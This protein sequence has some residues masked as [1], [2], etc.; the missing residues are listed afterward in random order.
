MIEKIFK[1]RE[2]YF[3][4]PALNTSR[5]KAFDADPANMLKDDTTTSNALS[6][7]SAAD[8]LLYDGIEAY[9]QQFYISRVAVPTE[10]A[11]TLANYLIDFAKRTQEPI[12]EEIFLQ[13][14]ETLNLWSNIKDPVKRLAK[15]TPD[16]NA[17]I[18]ESVAQKDKICLSQEDDAAIKNMIAFV[19]SNCY[20][21][22]YFTEVPNQ[23]VN[24]YQ[25]AFS[26]KHEEDL[27]KVMLDQVQVDHV[28]RTIQ[29]A[30]YKTMEEKAIYF[31]NN[32]M[33]YR[34]DLQ[35]ELY[36]IGMVYWAK[37]FYPTY[38]ILP[39]KFIVSSFQ[40]VEQPFVY[41]LDYYSWRKKHR[42]STRLLK[43]I[44][45]IY[46]DFKKQRLTG[47]FS[48]PYEMINNGFIKL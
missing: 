23:L 36:T 29:P 13:A 31:N 7:G 20:T 18:I 42:T 15:L 10:S 4:S 8:V 9:N 43:S 6:K 27:F 26:F 37:Q 3:N 46:D 16:L 47:D 41:E 38:T 32:V 19:K 28:T 22:K 48:I 11:L 25:L 34:Y 24:H 40:N 35:G 5:L 21:A 45:E 12:T 33:K 14:S 44:G 17:Y 30:D 1:N 39:F 2:E